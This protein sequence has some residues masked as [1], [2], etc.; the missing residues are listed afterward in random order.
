MVLLLCDTTPGENMSKCLFTQDRRQ[1]QIK[2]QLCEPVSFIGITYRDMGEMLL[3][4]AEMA[5]RQI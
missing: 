1:W 2:F 4:K 5:Q 3:R